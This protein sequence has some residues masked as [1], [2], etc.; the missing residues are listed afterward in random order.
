MRAIRSR[1]R[2]GQS[3]AEYAI[4]FA[5]VIGAA[6]AMQQFVAARLRGAVHDYAEQYTT[7]ASSPAVAVGTGSLTAVNVAPFGGDPNRTTNSS[8]ASDTVMADAAKGTVLQTSGSQ[9]LSEF[10]A[11]GTTS[12]TTSGIF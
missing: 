10:R 5:I 8:S 12:G 4:L 3:T 11:G 7:A 9:A 6:I 2:H 1:P